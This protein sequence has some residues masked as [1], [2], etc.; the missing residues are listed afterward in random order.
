MSRFHLPPDVL[1]TMDRAHDGA[2]SSVCKSPG[3]WVMAD[4]DPYF[5]ERRLNSMNNA[6][7]TLLALGYRIEKP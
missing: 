4:G 5:R 6:V 2:E 7:G 3:A 1:E